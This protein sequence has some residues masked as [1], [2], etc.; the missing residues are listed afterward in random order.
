MHVEKG[1]HQTALAMDHVTKLISAFTFVKMAVHV[2]LLM[3]VVIID[4]PARC[5]TLDTTVK[6]QLL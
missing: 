5:S 3:M 4:V 1:K 6:V 2:L